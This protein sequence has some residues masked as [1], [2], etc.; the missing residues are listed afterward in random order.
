MAP[1]KIVGLVFNGDDRPLSRYYGSYGG[2][3][4]GSRNGASLARWAQRAKQAGDLVRRQP[5]RREP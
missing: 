2:A 1:A 3:E 5:S 4:G